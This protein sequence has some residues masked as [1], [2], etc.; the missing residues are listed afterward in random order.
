M[1]VAE[2]ARTIAM[3]AKATEHPLPTLPLKKGE[4]A[5][6][7]AARGFAG[8]DAIAAG[9]FAGEAAD[10]MAAAHD[11]HFWLRH[12]ASLV[13]WAVWRF[14]GS[15]QRGLHVGCG[16]GAMMAAL[17]ERWPDLAMEG[18]DISRSA[19][20]VAARRLPDA[21]L[22]EVDAARLNFEA[23]YDLVGLFDV[24]EHIE[25]DGAVLAGVARA[26]TPGG[27]IVLTVPQ[28]EFLWSHLD[29]LVGH[30]RRYRARHL[31]GQLR[32]AGFEVRAMISTGALLLPVAALARFAYRNAA[33][34]ADILRLGAFANAS[35]HAVNGIERALIRRGVR[36]PFGDSLLAIARK[37]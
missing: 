36:F 4:G 5:L 25:D 14:S 11:R 2:A 17:T 19:L 23:Q 26:L 28:H 3:W 30:R 13:L 32:G 1:G 31:A 8:E 6:A 22:H 24:L 35:F 20:A 10:A 29:V 34:V 9:G 18:A 33:G 16:G 37:L 7:T 27:H 12:R 21:R 15:A